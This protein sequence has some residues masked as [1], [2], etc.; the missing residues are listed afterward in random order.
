MTVV[1]TIQDPEAL[2]LTVVADLAAPPSR[3]WQVWA[4]PRPLERWWGPPTWPATFTEHHLRVGGGAQYFMTG[5]D[6]EGAHGW[7]RFTA[8][9]EPR[10]LEFEDGF[11]DETGHA[12]R[13]GPDR[14]TARRGPDGLTRS[15]WRAQPRGSGPSL[16]LT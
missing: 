3:V 15:S 9:D 7:W 14:R 8:V 13:D 12:R 16:L 2:T 5:P 1:S 11:S 10:S 6:G 4:D